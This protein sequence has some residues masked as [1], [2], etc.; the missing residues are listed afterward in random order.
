M[1]TRAAPCRTSHA[2]TRAQPAPPSTHLRGLDAPKVQVGSKLGLQNIHSCRLLQ[3]TLCCAEGGQRQQGR[4]GALAQCGLGERRH[5][6]EGREGSKRAG[7]TRACCSK[8]PSKPGRGAAGSVLLRLRTAHPPLCTP[9]RAPTWVHRRPHSSSCS[10]AL[11]AGPSA[12]SSKLAQSVSAS[13]AACDLAAGG[14]AAWCRRCRCC[15]HC[16]GVAAPL[17]RWRDACVSCDATCGGSGWT[18]G[19]RA[20][21]LLAGGA[22]RAKAHATLANMLCV[23]RSTATDCRAMTGCYCRRGAPPP[24]DVQSGAGTVLSVASNV[25]AQSGHL[26]RRLQAGYSSQMAMEATEEVSHALCAGRDTGAA[27]A[28]TA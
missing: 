7:K 23:N 20:K 16:C 18:P 14:A 5:L 10:V 11:A 19:A 27:W 28:A 6:K 24:P 13:G 15:R 21:P 25:S 3:R 1:S 22:G 8:R 12:S 26:I 9:R 17:C 4:R 2:A